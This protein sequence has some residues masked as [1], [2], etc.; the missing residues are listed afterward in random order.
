MSPLVVLVPLLVAV[1]LASVL[2]VLWDRWRS[3]RRRA[4]LLGAPD[5]SGARARG[6]IE[7]FTHMQDSS[8]A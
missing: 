2:G 4:A 7:Y 8:N 5:D 3:G 6:R 1:V